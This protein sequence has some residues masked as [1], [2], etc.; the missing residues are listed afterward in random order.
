MYVST[1]AKAAIEIAPLVGELLRVEL[2]ETDDWRV[3]Q[4]SEFIQIA[5]QYIL[6]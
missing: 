5:D 1:D 3:E 6:K 4:I 2:N